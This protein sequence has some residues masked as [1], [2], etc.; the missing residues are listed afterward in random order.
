MPDL[1]ATYLFIG[2]HHQG[3]LSGNRGHAMIEEHYRCRVTLFSLI[4]AL[5]MPHI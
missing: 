5:S 1:A 2:F 3:S 4:K